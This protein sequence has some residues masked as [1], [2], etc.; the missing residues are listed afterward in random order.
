MIMHPS[1]K[2][3]EMYQIANNGKRQ[4]VPEIRKQMI[5]H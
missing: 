5:M 2:T 1:I 3:C 4:S